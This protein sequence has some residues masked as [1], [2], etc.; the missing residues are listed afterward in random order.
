LKT[1]HPTPLP[2]YRERAVF[3]RFLKTSA[4]PEDLLAV[5]GEKVAEP[6]EGSAT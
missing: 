1:S 2:E 4:G 6:D 3:I 5:L